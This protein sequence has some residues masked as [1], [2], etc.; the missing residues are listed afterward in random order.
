VSRLDRLLQGAPETIEHTEVPPKE[1][2]YDYAAFLSQTPSHSTN[3]SLKLYESIPEVSAWYDFL[4]RS[5]A[6]WWSHPLTYHLYMSV[7]NQKS[8]SGEEGVVSHQ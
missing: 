8:N 3:E 1:W 2:L 4:E 6:E 5:P 7:T